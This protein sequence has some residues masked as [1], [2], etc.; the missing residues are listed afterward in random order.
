MQPVETAVS[1]ANGNT[2]EA[3]AIQTPAMPD[4]PATNGDDAPPPSFAD[5][6]VS[7]LW[8]E[9]VAIR[10]EISKQQ[11]SAAVAEA[12]IAKAITKE[13][14]KLADAEAA[15][16][17]AN[18]AITKAQAAIRAQEQAQADAEAAIASATA[19]ADLARHN[20][21]IASHEA[22]VEIIDAELASR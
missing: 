11:K 9:R 7:E 4:P 20:A 15:I 8:K 18:R 19:D 2:A 17:N 22:Q 1:S 16:A 12:R 13:E 5:L 6:T 3:A 14:K 21:D 10:K